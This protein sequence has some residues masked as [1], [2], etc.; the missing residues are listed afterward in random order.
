M[1]YGSKKRFRFSLRQLLLLVAVVAV[2][3]AIYS[4]FS[5]LLRDPEHARLHAEIDK[6]TN[7]KAKASKVL[8]GQQPGNK[9]WA[10]YSLR[11][12][13]SEIPK[14]EQELREAEISD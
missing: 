10:E 4:A 3:A 8:S 9:E 13:N 1:A 14:L 11:N 7:L 6:W 5:N 2:S 12:A